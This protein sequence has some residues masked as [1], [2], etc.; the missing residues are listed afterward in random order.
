MKRSGISKSTRFAVLSRDGFRCRYCGANACEDR[1]EVDHFHP[2]SRGGS[3]H[4]TNLVTAC[5]TCNAGKSALELRAVPLSLDDEQEIFREG[6][7]IG[8]RDILATLVSN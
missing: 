5:R 7:Q 1:L 4:A 2:V 3:N 8:R 6:R